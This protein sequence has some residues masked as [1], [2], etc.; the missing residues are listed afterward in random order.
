M[1]I[2][3]LFYTS[4]MLFWITCLAGLSLVST[5]APRGGIDVAGLTL[6][7]DREMIAGF[8]SAMDMIGLSATQQI[9]LFGAA[10]T[11]NLAAA[12]LL[13]FS[14]MFFAF[15]QEREQREARALAE[16]A[17]VCVAAAAAMIVLISMAG[18][19]SGPLLAFELAAIAGL[20]LTVRTVSYATVF[21]EAFH[22]GE[23]ATRDDIDTLIA[24]QAASHAMFSAQ[25]ASLSRRENRP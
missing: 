12:G 10:S 15:G 21:P 20:L 25:L 18:G 6:F 8:A 11:L 1:F 22:D 24:R 13:L 9:I 5:Y 3:R 7:A 17:A 19:R 23:E 16:G 14:M 2:T 4:M